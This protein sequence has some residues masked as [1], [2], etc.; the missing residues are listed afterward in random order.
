MICRMRSLWKAYDIEKAMIKFSPRSIVWAIPWIHVCL[1]LIALRPSH[2]SIMNSFK[3]SVFFPI[4]K[5]PVN[6]SPGR[7][8]MGKHSPL[9]TCFG[10]IEAG[11]NNLPHIHSS[12]SSSF[13]WLRN[14]FFY[15]FPFKVGE[16][17]RICFNHILLSY[18]NREEFS[19][20]LLGRWHWRLEFF[21]FTL[22]DSYRKIFHLLQHVF[23]FLFE[24]NHF[25]LQLFNKLLKRIDKLFF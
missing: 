2:H 22:D 13:L 19:N 23:L 14:E 5:V 20:R 11:V 16:V 10:E 21:F 24:R 15:D 1:Y 3:C 12:L 6:C 25:F 8:F 7:I 17:G 9:A 18:F 4:W